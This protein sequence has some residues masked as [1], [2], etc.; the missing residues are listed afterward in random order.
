MS[1]G[2]EDGYDFSCVQNWN[3]VDGVWCPKCHTS[4]HVEEI[5]DAYGDGYIEEWDHCYAEAVPGF[6]PFCGEKL[7]EG[8]DDEAR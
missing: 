2:Y 1:D 4:F 3:P 6:C 7:G 8:A 5:Q